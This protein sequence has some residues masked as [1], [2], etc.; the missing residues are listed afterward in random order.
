MKKKNNLNIAI[1]G[2]DEI[3]GRTKKILENTG[4]LSL[5]TFRK[6]ICEMIISSN[7]K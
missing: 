1:L 3:I 7:R 2:D 5:W 4:F 6:S